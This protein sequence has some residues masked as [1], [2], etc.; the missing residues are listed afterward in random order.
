MFAALALG[1]LSF[2]GSLLQGIGA[3]QASK[4]QARMQMIADELARQR[5]EAILAEVN[6]KRTEARDW[7]LQSQNIVDVA[8][9]AGFNP[10]TFINAGGLGYLTD[11]MKYHVPDYSL[12]QAS[13]VPQQHSMLSAFGGALS[14]GAS[15][16]GTQ[17]RADQS[18]DLQSQ[19]LS[20]ARDAMMFGLSQSP[21]MRSTVSYG[22]GGSVG[23]GGA[24]STAM[25]GAG[26]A[27]GLSAMP[28]PNKW[29]RGKVEG[30]NPHRTWQIDPNESDAE[31]WETRYGDVAQEVKGAYNMVADTVRTV[32]GRSIGDWGKA[33]GTWWTAPSGLSKG[34]SGNVKPYSPF[35]GAY[36]SWA[37]P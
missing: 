23:S 5:N 15:A 26:A 22:G 32:T 29:E 37:S 6:T 4:K 7:L 30:T 14:A 21:S 10:V 11:A 20:D 28:Y 8:E 13:Q 1:A 2:G 33:V 34:F 24:F 16:F 3:G 9:N 12:V 19:K 25:R 36:P 18:Y 35:A 27:T 17:Y 31:A